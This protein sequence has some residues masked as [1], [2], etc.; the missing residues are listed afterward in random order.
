MISCGTRFVAQRVTHILRSAVDIL[1]PPRCLRC[2]APVAVQGTLCAACWAQV[3]FISAP[4]CPV[5][6]LPGSDDPQTCGD[7]RRQP[8]K[9]RAAR[10]AILYDDGGRP[11]V[12]R[13]KHGGRVE[14]ARPC[15]AWMVRAGA[16]L[17]PQADWLVPVP[18]H[19][20]RLARRGYNQA[21]LLAQE[22]AR[23]SGRPLAID[24]LHRIRATRPLG[25][26]DRGQRR[27][28]VVG[29]FAVP[30]RWQERFAGK[31]LLLVDDVL[32]TGATLSEAARVLKRAGAASVSALTLARVPPP[33]ED[34]AGQSPVLPS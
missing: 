29:I 28:A 9:L 6:G 32:T 27:R 3:S 1:L 17:L 14:A 15:A 11:L 23:L 33:E 4:F 20:W 26:M 5:C 31:H 30:G 2:R 13:F 21:A 18:L 34:T 7:C 8:L 25:G 24:G 16:D 12:L 22:V 19:R 10:A